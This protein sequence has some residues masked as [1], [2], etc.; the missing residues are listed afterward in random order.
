M[1]K[2]EKSYRVFYKNTI[3]KDTDLVIPVCKTFN[4]LENATDFVYEINSEYKKIKLTSLFSSNIEHYRSFIEIE[5]ITTTKIF[6]KELMVDI[7]ELDK[8][9]RSVEND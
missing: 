5:E 4:S 6:I 3:S 9:R 8:K 1:K 7:S 2:V